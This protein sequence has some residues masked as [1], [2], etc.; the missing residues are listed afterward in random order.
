MS[1]AELI[2]IL[3][4]EDVREEKSGRYSLMGVYPTKEI[5][6]LQL[7]TIISQ[8]NIVLRF[9]GIQ[10]DTADLQVKFTAPDGQDSRPVQAQKLTSTTPDGESL[11]IICIAPI[12]L[13]LEGKH[14]ILIKVG[15]D[16]ND[17]TYFNVIK[18]NN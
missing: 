6:V 7:P 13:S 15:D 16:I 4:C 10:A 8:F 2:D 18:K 9:I 5:H 1:T 11:F 3:F 17:Q 14:S 12:H